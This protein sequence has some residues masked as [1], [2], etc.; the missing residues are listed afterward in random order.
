MVELIAGD[1]ADHILSSFVL[2]FNECSK[3]HC[4]EREIFITRLIAIVSN[5][6]DLLFV[7][8]G[9]VELWLSCGFDNFIDPLL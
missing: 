9:L 8:F 1:D 7:W 2:S 5:P 4:L 3:T 6:I